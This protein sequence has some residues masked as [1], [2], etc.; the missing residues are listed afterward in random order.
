MVKGTGSS[1]Q[2]YALD[3]EHVV[4]GK[5]PELW[6]SDQC[7]L[8]DGIDTPPSPFAVPVVANGQVFVV[9]TLAGAYRGV[10]S[11]YGLT[12]AACN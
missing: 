12:S 4:D 2:L 11:V 5:I 10:L 8:R 1:A 7:G 3:A 9:S 6:N